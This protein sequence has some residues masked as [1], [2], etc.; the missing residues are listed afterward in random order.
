[1]EDLISDG[2]HLRIPKDCESRGTGVSQIEELA[3]NMTGHVRNLRGWRFFQIRMKSFQTPS[4]APTPSERE[5][6]ADKEV[7][8]QDPGAHLDELT[9]ALHTAV[10][11]QDQ[12]DEPAEDYEWR[13]AEQT[14]PA[15]A[16]QPFQAEKGDKPY[17]VDAE[18][19]DLPRPGFQQADPS[20][21]WTATP[22]SVLS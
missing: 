18:D 12:Q 17:R 2:L 16:M 1:M 19:C 4:A 3:E 13:A 10:D 20:C 11:R 9:A 14:R 15:D 5:E 22:S 21:A 7:P 8:Q 6:A